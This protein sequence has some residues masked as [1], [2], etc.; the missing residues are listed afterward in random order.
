M[1][2]KHYIKHTYNCAHFVADYYQKHLSTQIPVVNEFDLSFVVWMR[3]NFTEIN[4]P[5]E[6]CL[7]YMKGL[8]GSTHIGV[9]SGNMVM[10][11]YKPNSGLGSVCKHTLGTIKLNY[12]EVSFWKWSP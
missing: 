7:V 3:R 10:H 5:E 12:S 8:D 2:G 6:H 9:Y 4:R 11:N 1:I